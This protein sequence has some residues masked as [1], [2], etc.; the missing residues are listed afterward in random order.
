MKKVLGLIALV[1]IVGAGWM[2]WALRQPGSADD[3]TGDDESLPPSVR[4]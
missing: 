3:R 4:E 2:H 1:A